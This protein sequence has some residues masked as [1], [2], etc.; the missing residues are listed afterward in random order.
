LTIFFTSAAG[1]GLSAWK[2][3]VPFPEKYGFSSS[4]TDGLAF[5]PS[6]RKLYAVTGAYD[7]QVVFRVIHLGGLT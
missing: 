3:I 1:R 4:P 6:G 5:S 2:R 7:D